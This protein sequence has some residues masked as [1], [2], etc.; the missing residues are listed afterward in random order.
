MRLIF[1]FILA[2]S[3][4]SGSA[5][6]SGGVSCY[7]NEHTVEMSAK[8]EKNNS[9][10]YDIRIQNSEKTR[11][12]KREDVSRMRTNDVDFFML[13][14]VQTSGGPEELELDTH[15]SKTDGDKKSSQGFLTN[16]TQKSERLPVT[17]KFQ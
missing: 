16:K 3:P 6:K 17:C 14:V 15:Y 7:D 13:F 1:I 10:A 11:L 5:E 8:L 2:L 12:V 4:K 9:A